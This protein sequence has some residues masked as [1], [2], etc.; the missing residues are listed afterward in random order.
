MKVIVD[1]F[2]GNY[3]VVEIDSNKFVN[4]PKELIP[5]AK[6]GDIININ[7]DYDETNKRREHIKG[8][9]DSLFED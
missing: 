7:I 8:L 5:N 6:E 1:R 2:E 3:A 4:M 9:V